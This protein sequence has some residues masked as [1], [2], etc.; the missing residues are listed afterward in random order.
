MSTPAETAGDVRQMEV[1]A[2]AR[3]LSTLSRIDYE[4]AHL[5][6]TPTA[7]DLTA[8]QWA[9]SILEGASASTRGALRSGWASLGLQLG[10]SG[11][12]DLVLG[13]DVRRSDPDFALL[14]PAGARLGLLGEVLVMRQADAVLLSTF[15]QLNNPAARGLWAGVA[16][17][18]RQVVRRLL[19]QGVR[20]SDGRSR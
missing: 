18:H 3:E 10:S 4:D 13:W 6:E 16:P 2:A 17:G 1:P 14:V 7:Q 19:E 15:L 11:D 5:A 20:R 9:R 12:P 8:E